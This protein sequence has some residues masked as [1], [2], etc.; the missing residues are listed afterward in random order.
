MLTNA[1][2]GATEFCV[3]RV[4]LHFHC[5]RVDVKSV[6]ENDFER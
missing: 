3:D 5:M 4:R 2:F 6:I 1:I